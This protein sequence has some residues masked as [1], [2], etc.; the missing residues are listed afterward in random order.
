[1]KSLPL[2]L[3]LFMVFMA[4]PSSGL[5]IIEFCPDTY[6][7]DDVDEYVVLSGEGSL[8]GVVISDGEGGFRFPSGA[9][10]DGEITIAAHGA[11]YQVVHGVPP[12]Y[13]WY[14]TSPLIEDVI[15]S[16]TLKLANKEDQLYLYQDR[17]R[18]VQSV[19]WPGEVASREGQVHFYEGVWDPRVLMLGQSRYGP[20][21]CEEISGTV[22][23]APDSSFSVFS[24]CVRGASSRILVN[25]YEFTS[26]EMAS[27]LCD[28]RA[29][30]VDVEVLLEG[31]PVGGITPEENAVIFMLN[32]SG[33]PVYCM[34]GDKEAHP[35]YR[36]DHAKYMV[37]DDSRV[38][39][40]SENFKDHG[41][42]EP[43]TQGN[44]GWGAVLESRE[45]AEYFSSVYYHD[46]RGA[47]ALPVSGQDL[48]PLGDGGARPS[49][50]PEFF[51]LNFDSAKVTAILS[52]DTSM[53]IPDLLRGAE[54]QI[55]IEQAYI[56]NKGPDQPNPFLAEAIN[57]SRSG[58]RVRVILDSS[59]FNTE[60][61][62]DNNEM[63]DYIN[64]I[65]REENLPLEARLADLE[66]NNLQQVHNKG[67]IVDQRKVLISSINWNENSPTFNREAGVIIEHEAVGAYFSGVFEDDWKAGRTEPAGGGGTDYL[68]IGIA[69]AV[70]FA[71][72]TV[73]ILRRRH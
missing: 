13:E 51:P 24:D 6:L 12:Q 14:D 44:R 30:G 59:W 18:L 5:Q 69:L 36:F 71:L 64:R 57:A 41:F 67:V 3:L 43:V 73:F 33:I 60:E 8:D 53:L 21:I 31:G 11:D 63:V 55:D 16:G 66:G 65:A 52:P 10:I 2:I 4:I 56:T 26:P 9:R 35:P 47:W 37:V 70:L 29:R 72:I 62:T 38:F 61:D 40:T 34:S 20:A 1:M 23:A 17:N 45:L 27:L 15:R 49:F 54:D 50:S 68:K 32:K 58:V 42:P 19:T 22:F 39:I 28:A 46:S 25:V 7:P 48:K